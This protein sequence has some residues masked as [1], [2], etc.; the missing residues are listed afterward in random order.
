MS[1][2]NPYENYKEGA[3]RAKREADRIGGDDR[4]TLII[5]FLPIPMAVAREVVNALRLSNRDEA[6]QE[7]VSVGN[8]SLVIVANE[9]DPASIDKYPGGFGAYAKAIIRRD[10]WFEAQKWLTKGTTRSDHALRNAGRVMAALEDIEQKGDNPTT[11]AVADA[12]GMTKERVQ[13]LLTLARGFL[14][15][16]AAVRGR[17]GEDDTAFGELIADERVSVEDEAL[18]CIERQERRELAKAVAMLPEHYRAAIGLTTGFNAFRSVAIGDV[19]RA[20]SPGVQNL[21][22]R[23]LQR[24]FKEG[25]ANAERLGYDRDEATGIKPG[26]TRVSPFV[27][28]SGKGDKGRRDSAADIWG[29]VAG[30]W[31]EAA[32][33]DAV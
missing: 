13:E 12:T 19:L 4:E 27:A 21:T 3:W 24:M 8:M 1:T 28:G 30:R 17:T 23:R 9:Y 6:I 16:D 15:M 31:R 14:S 29:R 25:E 32:V 18:A 11:Q 10:V 7:L 26:G 5:R 20:M 2:L 22:R 33:L